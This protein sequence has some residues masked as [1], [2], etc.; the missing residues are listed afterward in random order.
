[1]N[2]NEIGIG[3]PENLGVLAS[4][5]ETRIRT[6]MLQEIPKDLE[7]LRNQTVLRHIE[8]LSA[9]SDVVEA[10]GIALKP[11]G[12]VQCF[13]PDPAEYRYVVASTR[14]TIFALALGMNTIGFRLDARMK[15]RALAS[16]GADFPECGP[17]WVSFTPFRADWPRIDLEFWALKAYV[18]ARELEG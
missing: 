16:G 7:T 17:E 3:K 9:H 6:P 14:G 13:C 12:D 8:G 18:A 4:L 1:M 11:L 10:L 15:S 5:R 2:E